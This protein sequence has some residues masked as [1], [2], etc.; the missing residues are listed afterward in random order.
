VAPL[1]QPLAAKFPTEMMPLRPETQEILIES[2]KKYEVKSLWL[3]G[4][5]LIADEE[6]AEDIDLGAE[7][8]DRGKA[9]DMYSELFD[10]I[11]ERCRKPLDFAGM[12]EPLPIVYVIRSEGMKIY[13]RYKISS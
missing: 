7:G 3:F 13:E 12:D 1:F 8:I 6:D 11:C 10:A 5:S 4:S 9:W 2:A